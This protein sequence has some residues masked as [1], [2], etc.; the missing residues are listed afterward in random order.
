MDKYHDGETLSLIIKIYF[1]F[2]LFFTLA[3]VIFVG[4]CNVESGI[5]GFALGIMIVHRVV[6]IGFTLFI[7]TKL[8]EIQAITDKNYESLDSTESIDCSDELSIFDKE[9]P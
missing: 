9:L 4:C 5:K 2:V 3:I 8:L 6:M 7:F 1:G